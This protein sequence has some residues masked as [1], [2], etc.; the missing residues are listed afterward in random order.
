MPVEATRERII[1]AVH[2]LLAEESPATLSIPAVA[3]RAGTSLRT[4]YRYFPTKEALVDAASRTFEAE[5]HGVPT[6]A[7]FATL[8]EYLVEMWTSF[9]K[10]VGAVKAQHLTPAGRE[11]RAVR[12]PRS[13]AGAKLALQDERLDLPDADLERLADLI[14]VFI[15]SAMYLELVDRLGYDDTDAARLAAWATTAM[16]DRARREGTV[17]P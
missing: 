7:S 17:A 3:D 1:D 5:T 15:G 14:V 12:L 13:R 2:A 8:E 6:H 9:T 4:V 16:V 10:S 11:L